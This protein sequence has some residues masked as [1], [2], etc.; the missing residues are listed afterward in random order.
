M[1]KLYIDIDGVLVTA[2]NT[3]KA[4]DVIPFLEF[5]TEHFDCYWLTTHCKGDVLPAVEYVKKYIPN[6]EAYLSKIKPTQW[7]TLKTEAIDFGSDFYWLD[8]YP[9]IAE[10]QVLAQYDKLSNL[11]VVN[12]KRPNELNDIMQ[13]LLGKHGRS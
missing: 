4:E 8:D 13:T 12:L 11:I 1:T 7:N 5:I 9:M 3:H 10:K 2:K 6:C